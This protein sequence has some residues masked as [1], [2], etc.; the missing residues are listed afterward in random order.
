ML[1]KDD[2]GAV[3]PVGV[4]R[5]LQARALCSRVLGDHAFFWVWGYVQIL[6]VLDKDN[7]G[8]V[9]PVVVVRSLLARALGV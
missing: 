8:A 5:S 6:V 4:V 7:L 3:L 2:L 1:D 9:L